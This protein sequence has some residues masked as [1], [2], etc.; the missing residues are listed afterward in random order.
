MSCSSDNRSSLAIKY[1]F[2]DCNSARLDVVLAEL[3][4]EIG[5]K[6]APY[7]I[8]GGAIDIVTFLELTLTWVVGGALNQLFKKYTEG[9]LD[10]DSIK[11]M[12]ESHRVELGSWYSMV[13][14]QVNLI[15]NSVARIRS[16]TPILT[17]QDYEECLA[18]VFGL[19]NG[20]KCYVALNHCRMSSNMLKRIPLAVV[21]TLRYAIEDGLP[22]DVRVAQLYY[23]QGTD[24]WPYLF[25]PT[26]D[27]F[28][29]FVDRYVDLE[30]RQ[31][32]H[33]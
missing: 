16:I 33:Y 30:S 13:E 28:G 29:S 27:G 6:R 24:S 15:I 23:D 26:I 17:F 2:A 1:S 5:G 22:E 18:L 11:K 14:N 9:L 21:N 4:R 20:A 19:P 3:E 7:R 8:R 25:I 32:T 31:V 10:A 12:G